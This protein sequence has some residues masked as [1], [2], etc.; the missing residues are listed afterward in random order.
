MPFD[1]SFARFAKSGFKWLLMMGLALGL[2][3]CGQRGALV[4]PTPNT[5]TQVETQDPAA[6]GTILNE[7]EGETTGTKAP[8]KGFILDPLL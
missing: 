2:A 3:A 8:D 7:D 1:I 5:N 6:D 4:P